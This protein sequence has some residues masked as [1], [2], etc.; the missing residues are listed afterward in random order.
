MFGLDISLLYLFMIAVLV[1]LVIY[2]CFVANKRLKRQQQN[3]ASQ[4]PKQEQEIVEYSH[5]SEY[6]HDDI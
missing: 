5:A 6:Y 2:L 4:Q 1:N 3:K